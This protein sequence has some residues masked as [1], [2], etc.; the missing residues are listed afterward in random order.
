[1]KLPQL[2][3][4]VITAA[5]IERLNKQQNMQTFRLLT[6]FMIKSLRVFRDMH[7]KQLFIGKQTLLLLN[8]NF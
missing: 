3:P 7:L 8:V 6:Y 1:M 4:T 2:I 5:N